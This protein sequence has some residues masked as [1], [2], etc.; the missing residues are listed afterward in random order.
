MPSAATSNTSTT[1]TTTAANVVS[2]VKKKKKQ[3]QNQ[4]KRVNF[5]DSDSSSTSSNHDDDIKTAKKTDS[6]AKRSTVPQQ[7]SHTTKAKKPFPSTIP[8]TKA[9]KT[10][11]SAKKNAT[12]K[13]KQLQKES[14]YSD[15]LSSPSVKERMRSLPSAK[16]EAKNAVPP[17]LTPT[18]AAAPLGQQQQRRATV[19]IQKAKPKMATQTS[20]KAT[21]AKA[22]GVSTPH[23]SAVKTNRSAAAP[24]KAPSTNANSASTSSLML[25][26]PPQPKVPAPVTSN[27]CA[28]AIDTRFIDTPLGQEFGAD[29][30]DECDSFLHSLSSRGA[31]PHILACSAR[32][33]KSTAHTSRKRFALTTQIVVDAPNIHYS[34]DNEDDD[35]IYLE[36][37]EEDDARRVTPAW[38]PPPP[39]MENTDRKAVKVPKHLLAN[40]SWTH[41][42]ELGTYKICFLSLVTNTCYLAISSQSEKN[43]GAH[44]WKRLSRKTPRQNRR[45][46]VPLKSAD[47]WM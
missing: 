41:F 33:E 15:L 30:I 44:Q 24:T 31:H 2:T 36:E 5:F 3:K 12:Q 38:I 8:A 29:W 43:L 47:L 28:L 11:A 42:G 10:A 26:Q 25:P 16:K 23:A 35:D 46:P 34:N 4:K 19:T 17:V 39:N 40:E 9:A 1:N 27:R 32:K 22:K 20:K 7:Q 18:K 13:Q 21:T 45:L 37:K 14:S 6:P